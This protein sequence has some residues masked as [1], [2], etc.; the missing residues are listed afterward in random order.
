MD[1][2]LEEHI[3]NS[4]ISDIVDNSVNEYNCNRQIGTY[5]V[6]TTPALY[7]V[8]LDCQNRGTGGAW[9]INVQFGGGIYNELVDNANLDWK[10]SYL[11]AIARASS[12]Q[13][14]V[15][16]LPTDPVMIRLRYIRLHK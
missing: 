10:H 13:I 15:V 14:N 4:S 9:N 16:T 12:I 5:M 3:I 6:T 2:Q 7:Y 8:S 11:S 1:F